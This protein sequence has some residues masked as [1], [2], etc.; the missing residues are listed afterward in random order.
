MSIVLQELLSIVLPVFG[1]ALV[2]FIWKR[3]K[4]ELDE[5]T[6]SELTVYIGSP[7]LIFH[8]LITAE[9]SPEAL[10]SMGLYALVGI[11]STIALAALLL[12]FARLEAS[13]FLGPLSFGNTGN[14][15]IPICLFAFGD[16]GK[17]LGIAYFGVSFLM[18]SVVGELFFSGSFSLRRVLRSPLVY[19]ALLSVICI[20]F[21][22]EVPTTVLRTTE[23]LGG[24][25]IPLMLIAL[26]ASL[27][28]LVGVK[29]QTSAL[30]A[31]AR[32]VLG[33]IPALIL[34]AIFKLDEL[35]SGVLLLQSTTPVGVFNYVL[36][37]HYAREP[38]QVAGLIFASTILSIVT[39]PAMLIFLLG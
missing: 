17:A 36:A 20:G 27:A 6:I 3:V 18:N 16:E 19:A 28:R 9:S 12:R 39:I 24:L 33:L 5:E 26:G 13:S 15:G 1:C 29:M 37:R 2:G 11:S 22:L 30:L 10:R 31:G 34:I 21:E 4:P 14:L 35:A 38:D 8:A 32:F 7:C 25:A 23:L